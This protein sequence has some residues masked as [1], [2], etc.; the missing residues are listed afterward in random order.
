M[1]D[2]NAVAGAAGLPESQRKQVERLNKALESH[3]ALLN[4]PATVANDAYN[5]KFTPKEQQD[6]VSKFGTESP[7]EKPQRG[8]LGTAWHY[9]GGLLLAASDFSTRVARAGIIALEE[10][11]NLADAWDRAEK[12]GQ[13]VFNERRLSEAEEKYGANLVGI[14]KKIRSAKTSEEVAQLMA[15][16]SEEEKYWLQISDRTITNLPGADT[17]KIQADRDLL[18]D[19]ISAVNAAQ[20]SPGRR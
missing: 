20:Y 5:T 3:K 16:A 4:L 13:K 19:A 8:W 9:T 17:K 1:A 12:D 6:L 15:T 10:G 18:D 2:L 14:A 7:E 11:R